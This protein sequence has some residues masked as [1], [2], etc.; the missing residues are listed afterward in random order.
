MVSDDTGLSHGSSETSRTLP[1]SLSIPRGSA[2]SG[3]AGA[4]GG[5]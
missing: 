2:E 5:R 1:S 4:V 3:T